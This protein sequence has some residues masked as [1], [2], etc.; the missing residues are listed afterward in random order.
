MSFI[1]PIEIVRVFPM[2]FLI[3]RSVIKSMLLVS[4]LFLVNCSTI[5][6][7]NGFNP[8]SDVLAKL[9]KG[10][11]TKSKVRTLFGE[12]PVVQ[13]T[14]GNTWIYFSQKTEKLAFLEP[15]VV[16]REIIFL[17]FNNNG[18]L[19]VVEQY[20]IKNSRIIDIN[21]NKVV[22]GGRKLTIL[23]QI[24]GNIGNFSAQNLQ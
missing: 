1:K 10:S 6:E 8:G 22:S 4:I 16:S 11:T 14:K 7:Y 9:E 19:K 20:T 18:I 23:Q 15:K 17:I 13:G 24:F 21:S 3:T 5:T 2:Y 12:P